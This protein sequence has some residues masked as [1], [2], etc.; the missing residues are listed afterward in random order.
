[1]PV[2]RFVK[3]SNSSVLGFIAPA[4]LSP[5]VPLANFVIEKMVQQLI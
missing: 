3:G 4:C 2:G 5:R 1:M